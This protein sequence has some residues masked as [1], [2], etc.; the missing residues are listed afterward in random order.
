MTRPILSICIPTYNREEYLKECLDSI[1][2]QFNNKEIYDQVEIIISN[3]SSVDNTEELIVQYQNKYSNIKYFK[4]T[5]P[6][7]PGLNWDNA[8]KHSTGK[9]INTI[10]DDD[11][12]LPGSL[13]KLLPILLQEESSLVGFAY[14]EFVDKVRHADDSFTG[15][16]VSVSTDSIIEDFFTGS[17]K[18]KLESISFLPTFLFFLGDTA[19]QIYENYGYFWKEPICDHWAIFSVLYNDKRAVFYDCPFVAYRNHQGNHSNSKYRVGP[20]KNRLEK[21]IES[22]DLQFDLYPGPSFTN[23]V[24]VGMQ[25]IQYH[26]PMY[27]KYQINTDQGLMSHMNDVFHSDLQMK[28]KC[29]Y[30][31][32]SFCLI[33]HKNCLSQLNLGPRALKYIIKV[34]RNTVRG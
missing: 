11:V 18:N 32:K 22:S 6:I 27:K 31:L 29:V 8:L 21:F 14:V 15:K 4:T 30:L 23:L 24:Y 10:G 17:K 2:S 12:Y 13:K 33:E 16:S 7:A 20:V 19:R 9:Y 26:F 3:N 28:E 34:I 5:N 1:V 25:D